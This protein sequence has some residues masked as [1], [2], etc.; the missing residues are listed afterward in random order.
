MDN[1]SDGKRERLQ[2]L[3]SCL[4]LSSRPPDYVYY[5]L[6]HR[7]ASAVIMAEQCSAMAAIMLVHSFSPTD[8][9]FS[10]YC[11][12]SRLFG[13]EGEIGVLGVTRARNGLPLYLGWVSGC[14][15]Y[16]SA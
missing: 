8:K 3:M 7:T 5:Q 14:K 15:R 10:D 12:F 4:A 1:A 16:L 13:I 6:I 9:W 2:Y 11:E